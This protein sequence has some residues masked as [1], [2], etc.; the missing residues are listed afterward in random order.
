[1]WF[2]ESVKD[3]NKTPSEDT[4]MIIGFEIG[5]RHRDDTQPALARDRNAL[6]KL[7]SLGK[8]HEPGEWA[9]GHYYFDF[10]PNNERAEEMARKIIE[11]CRD[12]FIHRED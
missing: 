9:R 4:M 10:T 11:K 6:D 5:S 2:T 7:Q 3:V 12:V 8:F 1:M